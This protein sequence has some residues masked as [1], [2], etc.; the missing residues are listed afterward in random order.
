MSQCCYLRLEAPELHVSSEMSI[1]QLYPYASEH[2]IQNAVMVFEWGPDQHGVGLDAEQIRSVADIVKASLH[3]DFSKIEEMQVVSLQLSPD[4]ISQ[5]QQIEFG[6]VKLVKPGANGAT[7]ARSVTITRDHCAVQFFEYTRWGQVKADFDR[8]M[9]HIVPAVCAYKPIKTVVMQVTDVFTWNANPDEL[10]LSEVFA[11]GSPWL[12]SHV[13]EL[14]GL[15]HAHHGF[16]A[17][18]TESKGYTQ[19][20][21]VNISRARSERGDVLQILMSHRATLANPCG[22]PEYDSA[23]HIG[24]TILEKLHGDNKSILKEVLT[25]QVLRKISLQ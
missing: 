14:K 12:P 3:N 17:E 2:A 4:S 22:I 19:L 1:D 6:G 21:N 9:S 5:S 23:T 18:G 10:D 7:E 24:S 16:F 15:W 20:D 8:Y 25:A 13:F 11:K